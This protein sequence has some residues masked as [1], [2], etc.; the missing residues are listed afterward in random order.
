MHKLE[1]NHTTGIVSSFSS[2]VSPDSFFVLSE[3]VLP[4]YGEPLIPHDPIVSFLSCPFEVVCVWRLLLKLR[5][6]NK[7]AQ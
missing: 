6:L 3:I 2:I 1:N 7:V 4:S 5:S